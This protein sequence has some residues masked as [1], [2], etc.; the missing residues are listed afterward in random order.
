MYRTRFRCIVSTALFMTLLCVPGAGNATYEYATNTGKSCTFC[1][2]DNNG[3]PL[4]DVGYAFARNDYRYPIPE[5]LLDKQRA[6]QTEIRK[7]LTLIIGFL[8]IVTAFI[9][10]GAIF[11]I[12]IFVRPA[13]ITGGIPRQERMLGLTC[14]MIL[15]VTGIYL[16][17]NRISRPEQFFTS[18]FGLILFVKIVLFAIMLAIGLVAVTVIHRRMKRESGLLPVPH[19]DLT[20]ATLERFDG[21][22]EKSAYVAFEGDVFDVTGSGHWKNGRHFGRHAAGADLSG[23]MKDAP[24]GP[25]VLERM[26]SIGKLSTAAGAGPPISTVRKI[27]IVMTYVNLVIII[28]ILL[29]IG[30]WR[31]GLPIISARADRPDLSRGPSCVACHRQTKPA[32]VSDW[33]NSIHSK[34]GVGCHKCHRV[35][36]GNDSL[37][38]RPHR[39]NSE[40]PV[41]VVVSPRT[42][43]GCH[44]KEFEEYGRSKHAN[45][46]EIVWKIDK[47]LVHDMNND[48]ERSTG[49]FACHGSAVEVRDGRPVPGTWPNVGVGRRNPDGTLGCCTSCHTRHR[50][51][52][53]EARKPEACDQ[54]HLGPD[55]PQIEIY[56]ESKHGTIYHAE[57]SGWTWRP[58]NHEWTA[59]RDYRAPTCSACHMSGAGRAART[60]DVTERL[61]WE[62][63]A[64]LT[65]RPAEFAPFPAQTDWRIEREKMKSICLQC[66]SIT[67][68]SDHFANLDSAVTN[69]NERYY[70]PARRVMDELYEAGLLSRKAYFDE[71]LEWEFY[72]LWHHEGRRARM[73][74]AMMAP[75]YA[76]WHGFYELKHRY[77]TFMEKAEAL[78]RRGAPKTYPQFPGTK[79]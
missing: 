33:E 57:G 58:D 69:Y 62:T 68:T 32:L 47:W 43:A 79:R 8:H 19:G 66:H 42:C 65:M 22:G 49:C 41:A 35:E 3:G 29:C 56:N 17:M 31:W 60:H 24:H 23:A 45:T 36:P 30:M 15:T 9:L 2:H 34:V 48:I 73:G 28:L 7:T 64:P 18:T 50:F 76:W 70:G 37:A 77:V 72:E 55:H 51:S 10:I 6:E 20:H 61:S 5:R 53:V 54:C 59:G 4:N 78:R 14:L 46:L 67:W 25:E 27:F 13:R 21:T 63:Q 1:H 11:Y 39:R 44:P 40:I 12:H 38:S 52:I 74:T 75:D 71:E 16:T 26:R